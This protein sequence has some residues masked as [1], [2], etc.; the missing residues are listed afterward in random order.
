[1]APRSPRVRAL[2]GVRFHTTDGRPASRVA[3]ASALPIAPKPR[4]V[5]RLVMNCPLLSL[6]GLAGVPSGHS[7]RTFLSGKYLLFCSILTRK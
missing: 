5:V 3:A 2:L 6:G 1:M 7:V 4:K